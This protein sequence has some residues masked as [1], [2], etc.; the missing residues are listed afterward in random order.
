MENAE[1]HPPLSLREM[2][3]KYHIRFKKGLGQNLLL[4]DNINRIMVEAADL[5]PE[6]DV[7]E[8]GAGLGALTRR[9]VARAGRVLTVEIDASFVPCLEE[10]FGHMAHVRIFRGDILNHSLAKLL[11]EYL[12][13][14]R[15]PKV[16]AN[17]PY[18]ITTPILFHVLESPVFF[19][20][21][22]VMMQA[23]VGE[24][25]VAPVGAEDY[26]VLGIAAASCAQVD[27]VHRVPASC[28]LPRP[29][30]DSC[31]VRFRCSETP[32][33]PL[34]ERAFFMKVVRAAFGQRRKTLRNS[35][36]KSGSF[37]APAEHVLAAMSAV[38][39]DPGRRPQTLSIEEF[40]GL[41]REIRNRV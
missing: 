14:S 27:I 16:V 3:A 7:L 23:E 30:V 19:S 11:E 10:Q 31:I 37:G 17:L 9:L 41:A 18:Y 28:F 40:A 32:R 21:V 24:R 1:E 13:G 26:G 25:L 34:E 2:C 38:G 5:S 33:V 29:N 15:K 4:D 20:R 35:L 6:E 36:T 22:V 39:I 8:V 12:P